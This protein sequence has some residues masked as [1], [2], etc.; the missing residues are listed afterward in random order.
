[1]KNILLITFTLIAS[2]ATNQIDQDAPEPVPLT[3][4]GK[5]TLSC[6]DQGGF[7]MREYDK[8]DKLIRVTCIFPEESK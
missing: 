1:M 3:K 2:C 5:P 8:D 4:P 6:P 7:T